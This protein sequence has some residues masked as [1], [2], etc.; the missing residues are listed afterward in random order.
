M[1]EEADGVCPVWNRQHRTARKR[2]V[3]D[4]CREAIEPG[5]RY[6]RTSAL[7]DGSWA[8]WKHCERCDAMF[9]AISS[10]NRRHGFYMAVDVDLNCG[11]TWWHTFGPVPPHI[12]ALAF[13]LPGEPL[14]APEEA[15]A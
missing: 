15:A 4:A 13:W 11:E 10:E 6:Y 7:Y 3:C 2:H 8:S 1:C 9:N 12:D 5:H 14:P